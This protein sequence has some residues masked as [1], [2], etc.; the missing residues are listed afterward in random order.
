MGKLRELNHK[1]V[2]SPWKITGGGNLGRPE[3]LPKAEHHLY[4]SDTA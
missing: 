2:S 1:I 4:P 3:L